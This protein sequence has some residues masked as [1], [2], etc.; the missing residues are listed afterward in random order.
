MRT[1]DDDVQMLVRDIL[2]SLDVIE[3][4]RETDG[5]IDSR[6]L[7]KLETVLNRCREVVRETAWNKGQWP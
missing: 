4:V 7:G 5:R 2:E 6:A 3:C 1:D